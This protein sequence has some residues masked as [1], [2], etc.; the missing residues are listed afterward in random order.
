M[1]S[2]LLRDSHATNQSVVVGKVFNASGTDI[3]HCGMWSIFTTA[4]VCIIKDTY[5]TGSL[6]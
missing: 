4:D 6:D 1:E 5:Y 2:H 3:R